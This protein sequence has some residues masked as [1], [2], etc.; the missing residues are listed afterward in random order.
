MSKKNANYFY[1]SELPGTHDIF[2]NVF[3][4]QNLNHRRVEISCYPKTKHRSEGYQIKQPS[5]ATILTV[6]L[7]LMLHKLR[8]VIKGLNKNFNP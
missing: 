7:F 3:A 8:F 2:T 1:N 5:T 6:S 4:L